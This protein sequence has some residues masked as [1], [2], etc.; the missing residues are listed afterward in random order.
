MEHR[1]DLQLLPARISLS[2]QESVFGEA[3]FF[4]WTRD[5][6]FISP[7]SSTPASAHA[8]SPEQRFA[9]Q[10]DSQSQNKADPF[11]EPISPQSERSRDHFDPSESARRSARYYRQSPH[12]ADSRR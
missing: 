7:R 8:A 12:A 5:G 3:F 2:W 1:L 10:P 6:R 11:R 9:A 4:R